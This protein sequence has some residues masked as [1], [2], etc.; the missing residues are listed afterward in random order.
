MR[1]GAPLGLNRAG[2]AKI[3]R[4]Q[5][6]IYM[7]KQTPQ[8]RTG[9]SGFH[10]EHPSTTASAVLRRKRP[11]RAS[12]AP[13]L[14]TVITKVIDLSDFTDANTALGELLRHQRG[15]TSRLAVV[16]RTAA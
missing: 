2:S 11:T 9:Q 8:F 1:F 13:I 10:V 6:V 7:T 5:T 4:R 14:G 15:S 16:D 3:G 12:A